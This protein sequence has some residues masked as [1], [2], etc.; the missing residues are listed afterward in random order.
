MKNPAKAAAIRDFVAHFVLATQ[1]QNTHPA[2]WVDAYYVKG[3]HLT[4]TQGDA[5]VASQGKATVPSLTSLIPYQQSLIDV[6][7]DA[8]DLPKR[9]D[10]KAEFDIR[11]DEV[12]A[13]GEKSN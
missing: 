1:W 7:Y 11:F 13:Q 6:I 12:I 8:G 3:Q 10:A 2:E 4:K 5:I 9:L